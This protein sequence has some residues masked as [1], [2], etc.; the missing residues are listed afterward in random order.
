[1]KKK[2]KKEGDKRV[3]E[4]VKKKKDKQ[5]K[6]KKTR[7]DKTSPSKAE[8][9][10]TI[11]QACSGDARGPDDA[12]MLPERPND[13]AATQ[14]HKRIALADPDTQIATPGT[15]TVA[16]SSWSAGDGIAAAL[17]D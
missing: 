1:M 15:E 8:S 7:K 11:V 5:K 13:Q 6:H 4:K 10:G 16:P 2:R 9:D 12:G 17:K 14:Q 3:G